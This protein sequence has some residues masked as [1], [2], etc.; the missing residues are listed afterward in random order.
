[1]LLIKKNKWELRTLKVGN[2]VIN[3]FM[4]DSNTQKHMNVGRS[5]Y[6]NTIAFGIHLLIKCSVKIASWMLQAWSNK[7]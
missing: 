4:Q 5:K 2:K 7:A 3:V 1:M 6:S